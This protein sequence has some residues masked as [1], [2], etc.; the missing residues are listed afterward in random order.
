MNENDIRQLE[1]YALSESCRQQGE[2][3]RRR[4]PSDPRYCFELFRRALT[5]AEDAEAAWTLIIVQ[6]EG[7]LLR[8][9]RSHSAFSRCGEEPEYITNG[10]IIRFRKAITPQKLAERFTTLGALLQYLKLC[11]GSEILDLVRLEK[12]QAYASNLED[13]PEIAERLPD[14][15]A[16]QL[17]ANLL[18]TD[19]W[20]TITAE[21]K[22]PQEQIIAEC[23]FVLDMSSHQILGQFPKQFNNIKEVYRVKENLLRRLRRNRDLQQLL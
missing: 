3:F 23:A 5:Q 4:Q 11:V 13:A 1:I 6:Y 17:D 21:T 20:R 22:S 10:A 2:N 15:R 8:W 16:A 18:V 7:Q 19:L 9:A 12:K 14:H